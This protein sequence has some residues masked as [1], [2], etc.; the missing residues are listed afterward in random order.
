MYGS[1]KK[2]LKKNNNHIF[3]KIEKNYT[4]FVEN[5]AHFIIF[6]NFFVTHK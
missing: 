4:A 1:F 2:S 5:C 6:N 3:R